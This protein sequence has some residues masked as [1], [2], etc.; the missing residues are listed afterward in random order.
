MKDISSLKTLVHFPVMLEQVMKICSPSKGGLYIDCTFGSGGYSKAIL[1]FSDTKVIALDRDLHTKSYVEDI[2]KKY[3]DRF[4][5]KNLKFSTIDDAIEENIKADCII[6]DLGLSSNQIQN[7]ERG[8]SFN[9]KGKLDMRM[10]LNSITAED[11]LN[12]CDLKT[13][14][15]IFKVLGE[16]REGFRIAKNIVT[17]RKIKPLKYIPDLID[18]I[19]KSKK[20]D[21]KKKINISTK[22]FQG[23]RI[24]VNKEISELIDGLIK[25]TKILKSGGKIIVIS[26]HSIE[27]KIVKFFFTKLSRNKPR[28]SRYF[29]DTNE[30][31]F[32]FEQYK[33]KIIRPTPNEI[34]KN[35]PSRSA[36]L[37]YATR[38]KDNFFNPKEFK[39]KFINYLELENKYV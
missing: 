39:E 36:K 30:Q 2:K 25:A 35:N 4:K 32:L 6:F 3:N 18:I 37:R 20:K 12:K 31:K 17:Q 5:F 28:T 27:D 16:E 10:G 14:T 38:S 11:V 15:D 13:L 21:F 7:L 33:N 23:I 1:S 8:F 24:F 26:F 9:S 22:T 19:K 29:P 34:N